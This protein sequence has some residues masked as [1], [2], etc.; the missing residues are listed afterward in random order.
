LIDGF[1]RNIENIKAW[2][3]VFSNEFKLLCVLCLS[4]DLNICKERLLKR[5]E[6]SNRSDD[7]EE[8]INKRFK[9]F[10]D[11][12]KRILDYFEK[13]TIMIKIDS[14][15]QKELVFKEAI[16]KIESIV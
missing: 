6:T 15:K 8:V 7:R 16:E 12:E 4:C 5:S 10:L 3:E 14:S 1:P 11:E 13:E 2:N 9:G